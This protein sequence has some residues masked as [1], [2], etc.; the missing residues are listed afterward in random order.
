MK[1]YTKPVIEII[2]IEAESELLRSS[3]PQPNTLDYF[4]GYSTESEDEDEDN[5]FLIDDM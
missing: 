2:S 3:N 1:R 5:D 4:D